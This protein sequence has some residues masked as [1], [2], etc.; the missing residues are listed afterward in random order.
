MTSP[1]TSAS[2]FEPD[3][4]TPPFPRSDVNS[5]RM[6]DIWTVVVLILAACVA[7]TLSARGAHSMYPGDWLLPI[8]FTLVVQ[9]IVS[10]SLWALA[11][12]H[13]L[14]RVLLLMAWIV[15]VT[16]SIGS[17]YYASYVNNSQE[18][19]AELKDQV[20]SSFAGIKQHTQAARSA[21]NLA[22]QKT[23]EETQHGTYSKAGLPGYGPEARRLNKAAV[24][25]RVRANEAEQV[26]KSVD[27]ATA[28]LQRP[29]MTAEAV[30]NLYNSTIVQAGRFAQGT[31]AP[32]FQADRRSFVTIVFSAMTIA[33][34]KDLSAG[35]AERTRVLGSLG[36]AS[37]MELLA[38]LCSLIRAELHR[39]PRGRGGWMSGSS[40]VVQTVFR[41]MRLPEELRDTWLLSRLQGRRASLYRSARWTKAQVDFMAAT[42]GE[43]P[44]TL[45][46]EMIAAYVAV[47]GIRS[48]PRALLELLPGYPDAR[49]GLVAGASDD[50]AALFDD[51]GGR[52]SS[53]R[54]L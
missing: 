13:G 43:R 1:N 46:Y 48:W 47:S 41:I 12:A 30:R 33:A 23:A 53:C 38:L 39:E 31:P 4:R 44:Q 2:A 3:L 25:A 7:G 8:G 11:R 45:W 54:E 19:V 18:V 27:A 21:A 32:S 36:S 20:F 9:I 34:G 42:Q 40:G 35:P 24:D 52:A 10:A 6:I 5:T 50:P 37:I 29:G 16:F 15:A 51:R 17:A 28:E 49:R 26:D 14:R 22:E